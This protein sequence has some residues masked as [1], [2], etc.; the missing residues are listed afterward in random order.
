MVATS[1]FGSASRGTRSSQ[2]VAP[3]PMGRLSSTSTRAVWSGLTPFGVDYRVEL[4][5][6]HRRSGELAQLV[7][8]R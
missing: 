7:H 2:M 4:S 5:M 6:A 8:Q 3:R 1:A